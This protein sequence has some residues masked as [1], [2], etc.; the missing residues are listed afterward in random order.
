[1][2]VG[3]QHYRIPYKSTS[4]CLKKRQNA[5][6]SSI[7]FKI[8]SASPNIVPKRVI[9]HA[10]LSV[11]VFMFSSFT[12]SSKSFQIPQECML[13]IHNC[14]QLFL[15]ST[16]SFQIPPECTLQRDCFPFISAVPNRFR[17]HQNAY[18]REIVFILFL[19]FQIVSDTTRM[20]T[21]QR[22]FSC[23]PCSSKSFQ[24]P[25]EC[26]LQRHCICVKNKTIP[27]RAVIKLS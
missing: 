11:L 2:K 21:L 17:Y 5:P 10:K 27:G 23:Y 3:R 7:A 13:W 6:V 4:I 15:Y 22:L 8:F 16:K 25:P 26:M 19:Q 18:F 14:F 1:M 24:T 20:H 12:Y 9:L